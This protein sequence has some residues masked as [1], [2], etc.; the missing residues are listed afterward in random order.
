MI[1]TENHRSDQ[2]RF[3]HQSVLRRQMVTS[4]QQQLVQNG[5]FSNVTSVL[6]LS[7]SNNDEIRKYQWP[8]KL[9]THII[10]PM[11]PLALDTRVSVELKT[12]QKWNRHV[13]NDVM[14]YLKKII[15]PTIVTF[16][17]NA[18]YL[19]MNMCPA[20]S[21]PQ[22]GGPPEQPLHHVL[23]WQVENIFHII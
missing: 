11:S 19:N 7:C 1:K 10:L 20:Q 18:F 5:Y 2:L 14:V 4:A 8:G 15:V 16:R 9:A 22:P 3:H 17:K 6:I 13:F 12:D 23:F 21:L